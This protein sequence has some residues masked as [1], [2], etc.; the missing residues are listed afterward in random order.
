MRVPVPAFATPVAR[1]G[2]SRT[3]FSHRSSLQ[4]QQSMNVAGASRRSAAPGSQFVGVAGY[5][6]NSS[7]HVGLPNSKTAHACALSGHRAS[8]LQPR[9]FHLSIH[10]RTLVRIV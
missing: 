3:A 2:I 1:H 6:D 9:T 4:A 5:G 7:R 8:A 10:H